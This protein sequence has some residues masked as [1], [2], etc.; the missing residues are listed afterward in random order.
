MSGFF[1]KARIGA[2]EKSI[3]VTVMKSIAML[4]GLLIP[5]VF[6]QPASPGPGSPLA[7]QAW[8]REVGVT[9]PLFDYYETRETPS[10]GGASRVVRRSR[11]VDRETGEDAFRETITT[12]MSESLLLSYEVEQLQLDERGTITV[13]HIENKIQYRYFKNKEWKQNT[14]KFDPPFL[15][16]AMI[17]NFIRANA[18]KLLNAKRVK[19][20]LA[21]PYMTKSFNFTLRQ[22]ARKDFDGQPMSSIKMGASHFLVSA[23]VEPLYFMYDPAS[24]EVRQILGKVFLK[25]RTKSGWDA[26][27]AETLFLKPAPLAK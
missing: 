11:F 17:P 16:G 4:T 7:P 9:T 15:V 24:K 18:E 25:K 5:S 19:F 12:D 14:E 1:L 22:D 13:D 2:A 3:M 20:H 27:K 21:V 6:A 10:V 23:A 26:F 8:I